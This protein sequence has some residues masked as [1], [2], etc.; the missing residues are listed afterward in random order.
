MSRR[1]AH[2][3]TVPW[4]PAHLPARSPRIATHRSPLPAPLAPVGDIPPAMTAA[5]LAS[6]SDGYL[7]RGLALLDEWVQ[8]HPPT[9]G[10]WWLWAET[11]AACTPYTISQYTAMMRTAARFFRPELAAVLA[12]PRIDAALKGLRDGYGPRAML[13]GAT[14]LPQELA[15]QLA[16]ATDRTWAQVFALMWARGARAADVAQLRQG[17]LWMVGEG[18]LG[19]ELAGLK[20]QRM[21]LPVGLEVSMPPW[22]LDILQPLI[23]AGP[24]TTPA[25]ARPALFPGLTAARVTAAMQRLLGTT[26]YTAHSFRKGAVPH[27]MARG[28]GTAAVALLTQHR[29]L[30]GLSPYATRPDDATRDQL[31]TTSMS[32]WD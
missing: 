11:K 1:P 25:H 3:C 9:P 8:A 22:A 5:V 27:M 10:G 30:S 19:I 2:A 24:P 15:M 12:D 20:G 14:P 18:V 29:T 23:A 7:A 21:G 13:R 26:A 4:R 28:A 16:R 32:L 6:R 31:R 17:S